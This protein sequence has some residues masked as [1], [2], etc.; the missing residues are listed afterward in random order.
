MMFVY[1]GG[2]WPFSNASSMATFG[3]RFTYICAVFLGQ[4]RLPQPGLGI[5]K[6]SPGSLF[7]TAYADPRIRACAA[8]TA[9]ALCMNPI[10][11][12]T[13]RWFFDQLSPPII[14]ALGQLTDRAAR[15][16]WAEV[17]ALCSGL[18]PSKLC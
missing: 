18:F 15:L 12:G 6:R 8:S 7:A 9:V 14:N 4:D 13:F 17:Q 16:G 2:C 1:S 5:G 11:T 3:R 10:L